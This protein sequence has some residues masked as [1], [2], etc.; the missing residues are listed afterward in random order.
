MPASHVLALDIGGSK[1]AAAI[2]AGD[3][4]LSSLRLAP[5]PACAG[6]LAVL[7]ATI[8]V[9]RQ[10]MAGPLA[11]EVELLGVGVG[12]AGHVDHDRGTI[13]YAS[14]TLPGWAGTPVAA[15]LSAALGL[16]VVVDNDVNAMALGE[17][18]FGAGRPGQSRARPAAHRAPAPVR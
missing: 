1:I 18:R 6:P 14:G 17:G 4:S 13:T 2:V 9:A 5:T 15:E 16:P 12:A 8:E 3:G 10:V 11:R 7:S